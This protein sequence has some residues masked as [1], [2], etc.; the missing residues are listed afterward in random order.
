MFQN[1]LHSVINCKYFEN[2]MVFREICDY[3]KKKFKLSENL[4]SILKKK[5]LFKL[6]KISKKRQKLIAN[7]LANFRFFEEYT[8][9]IKE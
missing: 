6:L 3:Y 9:T 1:H 5:N 2:F 4:T 8:R 7:I